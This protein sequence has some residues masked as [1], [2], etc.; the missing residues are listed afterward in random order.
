VVLALVGVGVLTGSVSAQ[1]YHGRGGHGGHGGHY[2]HHHHR[3]Y[4]GGYGRPVYLA[5]PPP[6]YRP[7]RPVPVVY[8]APVIAPAPYV[9]PGFSFSLF[10]GR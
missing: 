10:F 8:P 2:G 6:C 3:G 1:P 5:P 4:Y 7:V 9:Q